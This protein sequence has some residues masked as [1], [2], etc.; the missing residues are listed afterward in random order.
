MKKEFIAYIDE[1]GDEGIKRGTEW[2][3]LTAVIV[4]KEE[5]V[6]ISRAIDDIKAKLEIPPKKPFHWKEIRNKHVSKKRFAIDRISEEDFL[7]VNV[8]VNTYDIQNVKLQGKLLY[9]YFCRYL[10][11]RISWCIDDNHG[12]VTLVFSNRANISYPELRDYLEVLKHDKSCQIRWHAINDYFYVLEPG[13]RKM[14]QFADACASSLAEALNKDTFGYYDE[15]FVM[16]LQNKLYRR[17]GNLLSYGLKIFPNE[18]L[19][20]YLKEYS[21][22]NQIK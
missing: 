9:N 12:I 13:Q 3:I 14:L 2:F 8:A 7:Y 18:F 22:I 17:K 1:S 21:W 15:R 5:D 16:T 4:S 6:K 19:S 11:E 10:L 20:K